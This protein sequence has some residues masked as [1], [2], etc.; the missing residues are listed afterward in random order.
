MSN[1]EKF[2]PTYNVQFNNGLV[3]CHRQNTSIWTFTEAVGF[4]HVFIDTSD[5]RHAAQAI[6]VFE[7]E[8]LE[9]EGLDKWHQ[10]L[11][12]LARVG[13]ETYID[14]EPCEA[15]LEIYAKKFGTVPIIGATLPTHDLTPRQEAHVTY[16]RQVLEQDI[17]TPQDFYGEGALE[18]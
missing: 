6:Y 11:Q 8:M 13:C 9:V 3:K 5:N 4:D 16:F 12:G 1:P 18:I 17:L 7:K 10:L 14:K 15:D 2:P